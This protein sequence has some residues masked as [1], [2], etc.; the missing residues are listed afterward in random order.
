[1]SKTTPKIALPILI[2]SCI[3]VTDALAADD[4]RPRFGVVGGV[5]S[6]TVMSDNDGYQ[7]AVEPAFGYAVGVRVVQ[8]LH[9]FVGLA[10]ELLLVGRG[11]SAS[12]DNA[13]ASGEADLAIQYLELPL[14]L[15]FAAPVTES[16]T[17]KILVGP[18]MA[19][20]LSGRQD[21]RG[22]VLGF[23]DVGSDTIRSSDVQDFQFGLTL[24]GG[25]DI[26]LAEWAVTADL[27]YERNVTGVSETG[28]PDDDNVYHTSVG[29]ML[30]VMY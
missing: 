13:L 20:F 21:T 29:L 30:G 15:R 25:V 4:G 3:G 2:L 18:R 1:M 9:E 17:P 27:R 7:D 5:A 14:L 11:W 19:F 28:D 22:E 12:F 10:P 6:N 24:A 8:D 23:S 26:T 16:I